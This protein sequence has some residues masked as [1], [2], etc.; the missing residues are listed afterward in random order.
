MN[1]NTFDNVYRNLVIECVT[2]LQSNT[3]KNNYLQS[4]ALCIIAIFHGAYNYFRIF[5]FF[6]EQTCI[7]YYTA[8]CCTIN[9]HAKRHRCH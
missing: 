4:L 2:R 8:E 1:I 6:C 7:L 3:V 9:V 5:F